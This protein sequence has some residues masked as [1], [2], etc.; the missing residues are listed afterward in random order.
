MRKMKKI[1]SLLMALVMVMAMSVTAFAEDDPTGPD[2]ETESEYSITISSAAVRETYSAYK[3][4]DVTYSGTSYAYTIDSSSSAF[5]SVVNTSDIFTLT[6]VNGST[7][8]VVELAAIKDGVDETSGETIYRTATAAEILAV[9]SQ[10]DLEEVVADGTAVGTTSGETTTATINLNDDGY[11]Y[12]T[13]TLGSVAMLDTADPKITITDKNGEPTPD[14]QVL[15]GE[16]YGSTSDAS[17]GDTVYFKTTI[18]DIAGATDLILHDK[19]TNL[20]SVSILSVVYYS[21]STDTEGTSL[22]G[23]GEGAAYTLI[24]DSTTLTDDCTFEIA[25]SDSFESNTLKTASSDAYIVV[26]YTAVITSNAVTNGAT[27]ETNLNYG[28]N[29]NS[30]S[31]TDTTTTYTYGF[32]VYKYT[33]EGDEATALPG[34]QFVL[35]K[36]VDVTVDEET[37]QVTYYAVVENGVLTGWTT[38]LSA[39]EGDAEDTVY[40]TVLTSGEDG[41]ISVDGL[42]GGRYSLTEI[43]APTGYNKLTAPIVFNITGIVDQETGDLTGNYSVS[44]A[45]DNTGSETVDNTTNVINVQNNSGSELPSTGGIGTTIFYVVGTVLVL[46]AAVVLITRRRMSSEA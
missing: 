2:V 35:S 44:L 12:V 32:N 22:S 5:Y 6:Q 19:M 21:S 25:F 4:F 39:E 3:V 24:T 10:A 31:T 8:Y 46:G 28:E 11:Y 23:A 38:H 17:V 42:D 7:T 15:E 30:T 43:E 13:T 27:N 34:A 41:K 16:G 26:S 45:E 18:T 9:L 14:K 29:G 37:T 40:A 20:N 36:T 1:A 33:G